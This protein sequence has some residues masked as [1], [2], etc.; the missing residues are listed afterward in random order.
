MPGLSLILCLT[1][2]SQILAG[3]YSPV[4]GWY[5]PVGCMEVSYFE[6][7]PMNSQGNLAEPPGL[8]TQAYR[9]KAHLCDCELVAVK[10]PNLMDSEEALRGFLEST[11]LGK[12]VL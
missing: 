1:K 6:N 10:T 9:M 11:E 7:S 4:A 2:F 5:S 8:P 12:K 3:W